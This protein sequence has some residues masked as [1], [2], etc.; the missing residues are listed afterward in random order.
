MGDNPG[1]IPRAVPGIALII[2]AG[3]TVVLAMVLVEDISQILIT[4][5]R[6]NDKTTVVSGLN[7]G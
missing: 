2:R 6:G 1:V 5:I 4:T 7:P 3:L